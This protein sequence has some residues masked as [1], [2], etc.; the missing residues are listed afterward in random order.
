VLMGVVYLLYRRRKLESAGDFL[1]VSRL[2]PVLAVAMALTGSVAAWI[3]LNATGLGYSLGNPLL[4]FA[5]AGLI[6]GWFAGQMLL[7][8]STRVF[9]LRSWAGLGILT[10]AM[11]AG[12]GLT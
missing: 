8:R 6:V 2:A 1:A 10:A 12:L 5:F 4:L 9:Y 3:F 7:R 11:A